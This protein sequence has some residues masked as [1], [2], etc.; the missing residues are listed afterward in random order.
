MNKIILH[1]EPT[2]KNLRAAMETYGTAWPK[3]NGD[4]CYYFHKACDVHSMFDLA[5][6]YSAVDYSEK[7]RYTMAAFIA[8]AAIDVV[9]TD[10]VTDD[11]TSAEEISV[12]IDALSDVL[13]SEQVFIMSE[14]LAEAAVYGGTWCDDVMEGWQGIE[15]L[16]L[17]AAEDGCGQTVV[18]LINDR[19]RHVSLDYL[20]AVTSRRNPATRSRHIPASRRGAEE[21]LE[22]LF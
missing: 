13:P 19:V 16:D 4:G 20:D 3:D 15:K 6:Y 8:F 12:A 2:L 11:E 10:V 1:A 21:R 18:V 7:K 5:S 14:D 17:K 9:N 22:A